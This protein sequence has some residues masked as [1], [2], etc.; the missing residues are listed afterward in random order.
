M[1]LFEYTAQYKQALITLDDL[2]LPDD[3]VADTLEALRGDITEKGKNVAM[4]IRN[5]EADIHGVKEVRRG[6][7]VRLKAMENRVKSLKD[8][9]LNNM[10]AAEITEIS[11]PLFVIKPRKNP[12]AVL[13][14]DEIVLASKY[15]KKHMEIK[16]DKTKI[17]NDI[18]DGKTVGGA[19]LTQSWRLDIK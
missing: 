1:R 19:E 7:D 6:F 16:I 2:E 8:Y 9:L 11:C 10:Q 4:Y 14:T 15:K 17:K 12:P 18:K 13:I 3:V 5:M